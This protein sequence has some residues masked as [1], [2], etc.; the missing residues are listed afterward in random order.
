MPLGTK[1]CLGAVSVLSGLVSGLFAGVWG[2]ES[3][4][5]PGWGIALLVTL[6]I[7]LVA[8]NVIVQWRQIAAPALFGAM[9][10]A[11]MAAGLILGHFFSITVT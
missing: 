5:S 9:L 10:G 3:D 2:Y 1:V 6:N 4:V 7:I 8:T 11:I